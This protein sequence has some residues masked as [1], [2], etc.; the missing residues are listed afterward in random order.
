MNIISFSASLL[1]ERP[2]SVTSVVL[3]VSFAVINC[4]V[5]ISGVSGLSYGR[6]K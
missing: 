2:E 5:M 6:A 3:F 4:H 1:I